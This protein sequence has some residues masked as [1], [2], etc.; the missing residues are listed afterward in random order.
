MNSVPTKRIPQGKKDESDEIVKR[1]AQ[2][3]GDKKRDEPIIDAK[4]RA[5]AETVSSVVHTI[6]KLSRQIDMF[7]NNTR[8]IQGV[9]MIPDESDEERSTETPPIYDEQVHVDSDAAGLMTMGE[10]EDEEQENEKAIIEDLIDAIEQT[11]NYL[12][13]KRLENNIEEYDKTDEEANLGR[14]SLFS[15][16]IPISDEEL[17]D[18]EIIKKSILQFKDFEHRFVK[19]ERKKLIEEGKFSRFAWRE[20][21]DYSDEEK[22]ALRA[23]HKSS[24]DEFLKLV[25]D[26]TVDPIEALFG[27]EEGKSK[28]YC[29][30]PPS[31]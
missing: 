30:H 21:E 6:D 15:R 18:I 14:P 4:Y 22:A 8:K 9:L 24:W 19:S 26:K 1:Y 17:R 11:P 28:R 31:Q 23:R 10:E 20:P 3:V 25:K 13:K 7:E 5:H 29:A 12:E 16:K 2:P 27:A